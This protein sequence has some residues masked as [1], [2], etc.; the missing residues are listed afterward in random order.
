MPYDPVSGPLSL[1]KPDHNNRRNEPSF[2]L[3]QRCPLVPSRQGR[4]RHCRL[5]LSRTCYVVRLVLWRALVRSVS[6]CGRRR[7]KRLVS[8]N[9]RRCALVERS[10]RILFWVMVMVI[11]SRSRIS[12]LTLRQLVLKSLLLLGRCGFNRLKALVTLLPIRKRLMRMFYVSLRFLY[13]TFSLS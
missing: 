12:T 3:L 7:R 8:R 11:P 5:L 2:L 13:R 1:E 10:G 6:C 9:L 4:C